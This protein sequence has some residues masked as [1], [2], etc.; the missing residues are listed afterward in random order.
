MFS[1]MIGSTENEKKRLINTLKLVENGQFN[2]LPYFL[3]EADGFIYLM[4]ELLKN[5]FLHPN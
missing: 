3:I 2:D 5:G 1:K 4:N